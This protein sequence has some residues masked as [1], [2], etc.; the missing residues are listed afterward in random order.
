[1]I[2]IRGCQIIILHIEWWG[3]WVI[4]LNMAE[5]P[6]HLLINLGYIGEQSVHFTYVYGGDLNG[7]RING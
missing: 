5:K 1:M 2:K 6:V 4:K 3:Y 7:D